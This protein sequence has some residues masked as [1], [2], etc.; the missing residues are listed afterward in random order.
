MPA[1]MTGFGRAGSRGRGARLLCEVRSVNHR[2]LSTKIRLPSALGQLESMVEQRVKERLQRGSVEVAVFWRDAGARLAST[3][4]PKVADHYLAEIRGYLKK[5]KLAPDVSAELLLGLPG[6]LA[7]ADPDAIADDFAKELRQV[8]DSALD[9]LCEMRTREGDRLA[10]ALRREAKQVH[11][12]AAVIQSGIPAMVRN[13]QQKLGE[14]IAALLDGQGVAPDPAIL[15]REVALFAD[16][17]DVT[18][19]LDRLKSHESEFE[20]L[21]AKSGPIGR[22]LEFLVQEMGREVQT[23]GSKVQD[24]ALLTKVR[25]AKASLEKLREQVA[26]F[27]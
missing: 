14:R 13:Y 23:V 16:K 3:L 8:V 7:P 20:K 6:V 10:A 12:C 11:A 5:K 4:V 21:L 2:F 25:E 1:S 15:A 24:T 22:E 19:E 18:E 17:A 26:N 27:E 9:A